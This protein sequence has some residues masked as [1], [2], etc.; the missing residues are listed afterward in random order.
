MNFSH[1]I[2]EKSEGI[3]TIALNRPDK[4]NAIDVRMRQEM[5]EAFNVV[6]D[7]DDIH[8]VLSGLAGRE[9]IRGMLARLQAKEEVLL[10]GWGVPM[11][12]PVKSRRYDDNFWKEIFHGKK[13]RSQAQNMKDLGY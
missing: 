10:L 1:I 2:F 11:P 8:A 9:A 7:D 13:K 5:S 12:L 3:A 6:R 4:L